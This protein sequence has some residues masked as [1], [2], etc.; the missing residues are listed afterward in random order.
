ML[1]VKRSLVV[2][3]FLCLLGAG[4]LAMPVFAGNLNKT[5][6]SLIL[7][8]LNA[9][10]IEQLTLAEAK[11]LL[12]DLRALAKKEAS[13]SL[14]ESPSA[15]K[16]DRPT[17]AWERRLAQEVVATGQMLEG[18]PRLGDVVARLSE[19]SQDLLPGGSDVTQSWVRNQLQD[20]LPQ[21]D[22]KMASAAMNAASTE[23]SRGAG[24]MT[25][26]IARSATGLS[27]G[28]YDVGGVFKTT[29]LRSGLEG[30]KAA[31]A[32]SDYDALSRLELEYSLS[33]DGLT[34]YSLL[35][36]QPLWSAPDLRHNIFAQASY[37]NKQVSDFGTDSSSR[38]DTLNLG[39]GYRYITPDEQHMFGANA[40]FDHQWPYDHNRMSLGLDYKTSLYGAALNHYIGLS[41]WRGRGD[42]YEEKALGGTDLELSGRLPQA[43]EL[44]LFMKGYHW[45]QEQTALFNAKGT[46][47]WGYQ[48]AAEYTPIN[49]LTLRSSLTK[50]N[51]MESSEGEVMVRFNY[52][53]GQDWNDMWERP[54][55]N[56]DS[57][58]ERRFEKVRRNN[59]IRV[60]TRQDPN[61]TA[62]VTFAQGANVSVGQSLAFGT[63]ITTAGTV[64]DAATVLFGN[65]AIL[66]IGQSTQVR[67]ESDLITLVTGLIQFTTAEGGITAIAVPGGTIQL[68]GTDVD[69]R[70]A[71]GTNTLRVRDGAADFTDET[72]TTRVNTE[73]LAE[74]QST[75][76]LPPQIRAEGT[77][78]YQ[79]HVSEAHTQ[80][81]LVGPTPQN[82]QAAPFASGPA[83]IA[84]TLLPGNTLTFT[85]PLSASATVSGSP[86]L[87]FTLGGLSRVADYTSGSGTQALVFSYTVV[88]ADET[89]SNF[90]VSSIE[91]NGGTLTGSNGAPLVRQVSG[92]LAGTV[93]DI[94]APTLSSITGV[95]GGSN[96]ANTGDVITITL[97]A[98]E[99][100]VQSG[101]PTLSLDV[102]GVARVAAFSAIT[103]GNAQFAYTVQAGDN[104]ADG[105]TVTAINVAANELED[106]SGND[107]NTAFTLP[108]NV[109]VNVA[110]TLLGLNACPAGNLSV[111]TH[112]ACA[113]LFGADPT[114]MDDVGVF[115]G[116]LP[117]ATE[118]FVKRCDQ[119]MTWDGTACIGTRSTLQ[120]KNVNTE[121]NTTNLGGGSVITLDAAVNGP[122]NTAVLLADVSGTHA[123]ANSCDALA[124]N[125]YLP[126]LTELDVIYSNL[127]EGEHVADDDTD[128][129]RPT[130]VGGGNLSSGNKNGPLVAG[131]NI[132]GSTYWSSSEFFTTNAW[133]QRFSDGSQNVTSKVNG[134]LVRCARR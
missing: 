131:F 51:E 74:M 73:Q 107:L 47:I 15:L 30:L 91:K 116:E 12:Y 60:Q 72:G 106:A 68:I 124:G 118:I 64:G 48:M 89:L 110:T 113:R 82:A 22:N 69:V 35:T 55:Y 83:T 37:A 120:W 87:S 85:V 32:A 61:V 104:D 96:P 49:A 14:Y 45:D 81:N 105:I 3:I 58:V 111:P 26:E 75:D 127:A 134:L 44:E 4:L 2:Y 41:D 128:N 11:K 21:V 25:Q 40:F 63:L 36:V 117:D 27:N 102:G 66:D 88:P 108:H 90:V 8:K 38:R 18:D 125:W 112:V 95:S 10:D 121:S 17:S 1:S 34:E 29:A 115:A 53:F 50:D 19:R 39:L 52:R 132:G 109:A 20:I 70:V 16:Q 43:P 94:T 59:E 54:S 123:A 62:R 6:S 77:V 31:A 57:V 130:T 100:L 93:S 23:F 46:D 28:G 42:G 33:G 84:G 129:P 71:G 101:A 86:Q 13:A 79:T 99:T 78:I 98:T 67:I 133:F 114:N 65:G 5:S 126:A 7:E 24:S 56:L 103:A 92:T 119:G 97:D 80:L 76:G 9:V 122:N